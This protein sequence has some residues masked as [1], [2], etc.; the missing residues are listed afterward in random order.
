VT[1]SRLYE[2]IQ[3]P[4]SG[5]SQKTG[6]NIGLPRKT[7]KIWS[8]LSSRPGEAIIWREETCKSSFCAAPKENG[9]APQDP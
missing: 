1:S 3:H 8:L 7:G 9:Q 6:S 5:K 2:Q 4:P